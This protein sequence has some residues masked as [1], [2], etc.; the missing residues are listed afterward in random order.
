VSSALCG[1]S[2]AGLMISCVVCCVVGCVMFD[3]VKVDLA[4]LGELTLALA[5]S[6]G[7]FRFRSDSY[8]LRIC[9]L[10]S[11]VFYIFY[12]HEGCG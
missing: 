5:H 1:G 2:L 9:N 12:E 7:V 11:V 8:V 3:V 6:L 4:L 10:Q